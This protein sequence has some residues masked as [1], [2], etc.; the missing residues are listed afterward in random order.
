MKYVSADS[1]KKIPGTDTLKN[2]RYYRSI[3]TND[4]WKSIN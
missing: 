1:P 2:G 4:S 3:S